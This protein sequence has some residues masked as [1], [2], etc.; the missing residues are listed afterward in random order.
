[1]LHS[2]GTICYDKAQEFPS[3]ELTRTQHWRPVNP[4]CY[5][6]VD[7]PVDRYV[8]VAPDGIFMAFSRL[9]DG[10]TTAAITPCWLDVSPRS[11]LLFSGCITVW[12]FLL[13]GGS[14]TLIELLPEL[15]PLHYVMQRSISMALVTFFLPQRKLDDGLTFDYFPSAPCL[16]FPSSGPSEAVSN[17]IIIINTNSFNNVNMKGV[18]SPRLEQETVQVQLYIHLKRWFHL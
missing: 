1:M 4:F 12:L 8:A 5:R 2:G 13:P 14:W 18:W 16:F 6:R 15:Y 10:R 17:F 9:D 3:S 11:S 7:L